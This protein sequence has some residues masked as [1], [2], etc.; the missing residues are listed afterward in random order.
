MTKG[1]SLGWICTFVLDVAVRGP[2]VDVSLQLD[3][4]DM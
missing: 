3:S 1:R 2:A 4:D